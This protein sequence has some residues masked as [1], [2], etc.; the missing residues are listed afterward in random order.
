MKPLRKALASILRLDSPEGWGPF[1]SVPN[2]AGQTVNA[3]TAMQL[4]TVW[5]CVKILSQTISTLSLDMMERKSDGTWRAAP[6]HRLQF[7]LDDMPNAESTATAFWQAMLAAIL[8][9]GNGVAERRYS[10]TGQLIGLE[11]LPWGRLT[12]SRG[13]NMERVW[14]YT[15]KSGVQRVIPEDRIFRVFAFSLD[16]DWGLSAIEYGAN[17]FGSAIAADT[18]ANST[19]NKGLAPTVAFKLSNFLRKDQREEIRASVA[20]M[21]GALNGGKSVVLEGGMDATTIGIKPSDAQLL[22]SRAFSVEEICRWFGVPPYMVAHSEKSTSW[23]T[24]IEQQMIGFLTFTLRP[25]LKSVES[26]IRKD[27]MTPIER[28]RFKARFN[29]EDLLRADSKTRAEFLRAM[30]DSGIFTR[31]EAR[32]KENLPPMGGNAALLL[33]NSA[34][35]PIDSLGV[36]TNAQGTS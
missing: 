1:L 21:G 29:V 2:T 3:R 33:V 11:F 27:L 26:T 4:S 28:M 24:G 6:T 17:V 35:Q 25:V 19:F 30:V 16:G 34:N 31:D 36:Q 9:Q 18:S 13:V 12:V 15:E 8:L 20:E 22:E 14:R 5:A 7:I 23:G 10:A 32:L